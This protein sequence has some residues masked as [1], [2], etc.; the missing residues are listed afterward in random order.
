M[1]NIKWGVI[2]A[3]FALLIS[4]LFGLIAGVSAGHIFLRAVIFTVLFFG[5]GFGLRIAINNF[6]P[7]MLISDYE[8]AASSSA[9]NNGPQINITVDS[10]GEYAVPELFKSSGDSGELGNIEEL[11]SGVFG[12]I[13]RSRN[14]GGAKQASEQWLNVPEPDNEQGIDRINK[15][16]Y[17]DAG[18]GTSFIETNAYESFSTAAAKTQAFGKTPAFE[19]AQFTPD[20]GEDDSELGGLP[21]LDMM[22]RAFSSAPGSPVPMQQAPSTPSSSV[23][24][25]IPTPV[26]GNG[27]FSQT[28]G[29]FSTEDMDAKKRNVGNKPQTLQGDFDPKQMAQGISTILSKS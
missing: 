18:G 16:G 20:F 24:E 25:F 14:K 6:F 11:V 3:V 26:P 17:N 27:A 1:A 9:E 12:Q 28:A 22:A 7:E 4:I 19:K 10:A 29:V 13:N 23:T 5:A 2:T 8:S 15:T 21:D